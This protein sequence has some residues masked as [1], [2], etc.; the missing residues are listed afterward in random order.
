MEEVYIES[1]TVVSLM[2]SPPVQGIL[3]IDPIDR[4]QQIKT[5]LIESV[6]A[7]QNWF[8]EKSKIGV[9]TLKA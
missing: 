4:S 3:T 6:L 2:G 9:F 1:K 7:N 5:C 8:L